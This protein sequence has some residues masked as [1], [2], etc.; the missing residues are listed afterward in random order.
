MWISVQL[1]NYCGSF[2]VW[3]YNRS[4]TWEVCRAHKALY[5]AH[6]LSKLS[7]EN[8]SN[9]GG[10]KQF[11]ALSKALLMGYYNHLLMLET[12]LTWCKILFIILH[13]NNM[14]C[15]VM[16]TLTEGKDASIS[17]VL[18]AFSITSST[19][20]MKIFLNSAK[21]CSIWQTKRFQK[22]K[23]QLKNLKTK[24]TFESVLIKMR[25]RSYQQ[26]CVPIVV[27]SGMC[28]H[29]DSMCSWTEMCWQL[30]HAQW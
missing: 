1:R 9:C 28:M 12:V 22:K 11:P 10:S 24:L 3:I 5:S 21:P 23:I 4:P 14:R 29:Q 16:K 2:C 6:S 20:L 18:L 26:T 7:V 8:N 19:F 13:S 17:L 25:L 30:S 27:S 15:T